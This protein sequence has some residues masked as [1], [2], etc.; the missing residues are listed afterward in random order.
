M[1]TKPVLALLLTA[2]IAALAAGCAESDPAPKTN[3]PDVSAS[4]RPHLQWKRYAAIEADL[5]AALELP[6]EELCTEFGRESCIGSVHLAPL[7]GNEPFKTGLLEPS[8]E[9]LATTPA[10]IDRLFLSACSRRV[11]LD[12]EA[13]SSAKVFR[14]LDLSTDAPNEGDAATKN[15]ITTLYRRFLARNPTADEI[16]KVATLTRDEDE[17]PVSASEFAVTACYAV[18]STTEFEFY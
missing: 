15:T 11:A 10:V 14:D 3:E 1:R 7:G 18:G 5:A 12:K 13:G 2:A 6:K 4:Q 9:P 8:A 17:R 16:E